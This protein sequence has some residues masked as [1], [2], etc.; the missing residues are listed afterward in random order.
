[1]AKPNDKEPP[2]LLHAAVLLL[3]AGVIGLT[4]Y[5][6]VRPGGPA[7]DEPVAPETTQAEDVLARAR[8]LMQ[9]GLFE[10]A[11]GLLEAHVRSTPDDVEVRPVLAEVY[12]QLG[13]L[14]EAERTVDGLLRL[15]PRLAEALWLKGKIVRRRGGKNYRKFFELAVNKAVDTGP[16]IWAR[17]GLQMLRDGDTEAARTYLTRALRA[18]LRDFRTLGGLGDLA[19][20]AGRF[21]EADRLLTEAV[22]HRR[23]APDLWAALAAAQ[24]N[25]GKIDEALRTVQEA[26]RIRRS[27][28]LYMLR[29]E[30]CMLRK[31]CKA[32]AEAYATAAEFPD[33]RAD[34]TFRAAKCYYLLDR[35]GLAMKYIDLAAEIR[36]GNADVLAWRKKIEDARFGRPGASSGPAAGPPATP[37]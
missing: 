36:G 1:M 2:R 22:G 25:A 13:R 15:A 14:D 20:K 27:G 8:P 21:D 7:G 24:K 10:L 12:L 4:I 28:P 11:R 37:K 18:G 3:T 34:A 33:V 31:D 9:D 26:I 16:E 29:G 32:A 23:H 30:I 17:Y 19:L 35:Y 6:S 5:V